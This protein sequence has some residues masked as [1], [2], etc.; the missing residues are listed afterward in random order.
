MKAEVR[1]RNFDG[2]QQTFLAVVEEFGRPKVRAGKIVRLWLLRYKYISCLK[3]CGLDFWTVRATNKNFPEE[4]V[5]LLLLTALR[6]LSY[7]LHFQVF[8][9][10]L[11][12]FAI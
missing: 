8:S 5:Q 9:F 6:I 3:E 12:N 10:V 11:H 7:R 4:L 2:V 1:G